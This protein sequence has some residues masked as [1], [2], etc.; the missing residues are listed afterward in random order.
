MTPELNK[1]RNTLL[2]LQVHLVQGSLFSAGHFIS[3]G[4]GSPAKLNKL[5]QNYCRL[6][7]DQSWICRNNMNMH[8]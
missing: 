6:T 7:P 4:Q 3:G 1:L 5:K 8:M 2:K